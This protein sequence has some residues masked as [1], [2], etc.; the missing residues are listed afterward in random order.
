MMLIRPGR[1]SCLRC[2]FPDPPAPGELPTCD[3]AG[4]LGSAA[5]VVASLQVTAALRLLLGDET[6]AGELITLD[7]WTN[8]FRVLDCSAQRRDDC[9]TCGLRHFEFLQQPAGALSA[10]LCGRDAVQIQGGGGADMAR[11]AARLEAVGEVEQNRYF[12]RC[13]LEDGLILTLFTDGRAIIQGT[14]DVARA[15]SVYARYVG[16]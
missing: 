4:V 7:V 14:G 12:I 6:H 8:H 16:A 5:A 10:R 13:R 2:I 1:T 15:R 3:T 11:S 9:P